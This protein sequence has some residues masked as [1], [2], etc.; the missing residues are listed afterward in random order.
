MISR[1]FLTS[2]LLAGVMGCVQEEAPDF[3]KNHYLFHAE[4]A[5]NS[6]QLSITMS[7]SGDIHSE[8]Q[9][10]GTIPQQSASILGDVANVYTVETATE[11]GPAQATTSPGPDMLRASYSS[12]C[13]VDNKIGQINVL[14]FES[15]PQLAEVVVDVTTPATQKHFAI[16]R[17]C[18]S[19]IFRL[20]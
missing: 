17:Q 12:T 5:D 20:K 4:H 9:V 19:A 2:L 3:C 10:P 18:S 1:V 14:L 15:F 16:H 11:C 7:D 13:G 8:L 6:A